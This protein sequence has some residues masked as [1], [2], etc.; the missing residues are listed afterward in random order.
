MER[1]EAIK[2]MLTA[3]ATVA[4][5]DRAALGGDAPP[6]SNRARGYGNDPDMLKKYLP[7]DF[8]P[9]TLNAGQRRTAAA[10]CDAIMPADARS[11][12]AASLGVHE[13]IDEWVSAP[14]PGHDR[15]R[16]MIVAGLEWLDADSQRRFGANFDALVWSQKVQICDDIC[17]APKAKAGNRLAA[18][19][20]QKYRNLTAGGYYTTAEG[21]KDIGYTG[22]V[23][24][25]AFDGPPTEAL[26]KLGLA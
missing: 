17:Y 14:Y 16:A 9:L 10:L 1:R 6:L 13:F 23:P 12:S 21:M 15:D 8:W 25:P 18:E 24:I 19:F 4:F 11:P 20:F 3:T 2:W 7:G 26:V 5:L 22:N